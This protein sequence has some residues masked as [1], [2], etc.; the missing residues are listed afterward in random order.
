MICHPPSLAVK[1]NPSPLMTSVIQ[2]NKIQL[3]TI[4]ALLGVFFLFFFLYAYDS[5]R[6][7]EHKLRLVTGE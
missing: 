6:S 5:Q 7:S 2:Q 3:D 4:R 1:K